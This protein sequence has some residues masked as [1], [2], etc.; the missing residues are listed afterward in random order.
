[1]FLHNLAR[2]VHKNVVIA[3]CCAGIS[4]IASVQAAPAAPVKPATGPIVSVISVDHG[5]LVQSLH[6]GLQE[7]LRRAGYT[8]GKNIR[9]EAVDAA[10]DATRVDQLA[11]QV[12]RERPKVIVALGPLVARA[13]AQATREVPVVYSAVA[14]PVAAGL[15]APVVPA[16]SADNA[17]GGGSG[18]RSGA[19][20][21]A[22]ASTASGGSTGA[23][24]GAGSGPAAGTAS[25]LPTNM[26]GVSD[27]LT[28]TRQVD[29][30]RAVAPQAKRVGFVYD[31]SDANAVA[32]VKQLQAILPKA[33][34]TLVEAIA[35]RAVDVGPAAR[36]LIEKV[37]VFYSH[38]DS[39]AKDGFGSLVRVANDFR[40]PL[41]SADT[42]AVALGAAAAVGI[43]Y[44]EVGLQTGS[45][46]ARLLKGETP[47]QVKP[48]AASR[49]VL[50]INTDAAS[51]QGATIS[52]ALL[53]SAGQVVRAAP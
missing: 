26:T 19:A 35:S 45:M 22:T 40:I 8:P 14:D 29:L 27:A 44:R 21:A 49:L 5:A 48:Q 46:V 33:G 6:D 17:G 16:D 42:H 47:G 32:A 39:R 37:D 4:G 15:I 25:V 41:V 28:L 23:S 3:C 38:H 18:G 13:L 20:Q 31:P 43:S 52:E 50:H 51:Q 11:E 24:D 36:S 9:W 53:K 7:G 10:G 12:V 34:M 2:H 30:M 1:M